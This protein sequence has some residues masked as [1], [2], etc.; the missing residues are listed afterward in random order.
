MTHTHMQTKINKQTKQTL[1]AKLHTK[2]T[3]VHQN[4]EGPLTG[5]HLLHQSSRVIGPET[6]CASL[7][8]SLSA[9]R[10]LCHAFTLPGEEN[11]KQHQCNSRQPGH[12]KQPINILKV[13]R[14]NR[15][16]ELLFSQLKDLFINSYSSFVDNTFIR[17]SHLLSL[18][19]VEHE[20][21]K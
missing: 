9:G 8:V 3:E 21:V 5:S 15:L 14:A 13:H 19:T 7:P 16:L 12:K 18:F 1:E 20:N 4:S 10:L 6:R 17:I 2:H 11:K